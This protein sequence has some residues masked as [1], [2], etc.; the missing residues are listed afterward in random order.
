M[1]VLL[2]MN[3]LGVVILK[4]KK[5]KR[6]EKSSIFAIL[7]DLSGESGDRLFSGCQEIRSNHY[8]SAIL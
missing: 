4:E 6:G 5:T 3:N 2:R 8:I 1:L 7:G